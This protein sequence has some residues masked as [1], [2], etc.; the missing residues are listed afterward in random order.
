MLGATL[1]SPKDAE[2]PASVSRTPRSRHVILGS[3]P[4]SVMLGWRARTPC[5]ELGSDPKITWTATSLRSNDNRLIPR[6]APPSVPAPSHA[7]DWQQS[8]G[9]MLAA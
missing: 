4:K 1:K 8:W 3:E 6:V 2:R 9:Q 7:A 5:P